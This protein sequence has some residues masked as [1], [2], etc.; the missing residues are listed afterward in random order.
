MLLT[1]K[2]EIRSYAARDVIAKEGETGTE[3]YLILKGK[4]AIHSDAGGRKKA[5][6]LRSVGEIVGEMSLVDHAPRSATLTALSEVYVEVIDRTK[7]RAILASSHPI[8]PI[9]MKGLCSRLREAN[10]RLS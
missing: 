7:F 4:V 1:M 8:V 6:G 5:L 10:Q 3:A 9:A 2:V